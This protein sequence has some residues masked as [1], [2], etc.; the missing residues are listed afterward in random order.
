[1]AEQSLAAYKQQ[2]LF[3]R[4]RCWMTMKT[5][6]QIKAL[7]CR[8]PSLGESLYEVFC[9]KRSHDKN[10]L[11]RGVR[12]DEDPFT[13]CIEWCVLV[14]YWDSLPFFTL[15]CLVWFSF[16]S[17]AKSCQRQMKRSIDFLEKN[18]SRANSEIIFYL[19]NF[20]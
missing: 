6:S 13:V 9:S 5:Y 15:L 8:S 17:V 7:L 14:A 11:Q 2:P 4:S 16:G 10:N 18:V 19:S 1:M 12:D 3:F 20:L